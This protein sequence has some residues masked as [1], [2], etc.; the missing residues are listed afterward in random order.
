VS[1]FDRVG[2]AG[3]ALLVWIYLMS[4]IALIGCEFGNSSAAN[5][6]K[7]RG[8]ARLGS[9]GMVFGMATTKL[10]ITLPNRQLEEIRRR[11][12]AQDSPSVSGFVQ[13]AVQKSLENAAEFHAMVEEALKETGGPLKPRERA[14]AR[15]MLSA[16]KRGTKP[17]KVA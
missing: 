2:Y 12:A 4:A 5:V 9:R 7:G 13:Q 15:R 14:W 11:V 6:H 16:R 17:R 8:R 3:I 1:R 10:T